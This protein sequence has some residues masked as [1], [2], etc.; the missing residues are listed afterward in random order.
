MI[1]VKYSRERKTTAN[2]NAWTVLEY[3]RSFSDPHRDMSVA[4]QE[5]PV[6]TTALVN[7][8]AV[9]EETVE[10]KCATADQELLVVKWWDSVTHTG[11]KVA[12]AGPRCDI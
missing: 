5:L 1:K 9:E 12:V 2:N 6:F 10:L 8:G 7:T 3:T 4:M 11:N